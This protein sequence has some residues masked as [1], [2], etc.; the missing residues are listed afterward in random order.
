MKTI[1]INKAG[2]YTH[3]GIGYTEH[4][5]YSGRSDN[6]WS[7]K[8]AILYEYNNGIRDLENFHI[9]VNDKYLKDQA[10]FTKLGMNDLELLNY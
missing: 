7:I 4:A 9:M 3:H 1:R 6:R 5:G 2:N 8:M 10:I